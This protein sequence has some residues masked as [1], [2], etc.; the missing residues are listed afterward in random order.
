ME[1]AVEYRIQE[2]ELRNQ[3]TDSLLGNTKPETQN[4]QPINGF[5]VA[6]YDKAQELVIDPFLASTYL[7]G[8]GIDSGHS[9]AIDDDRNVYVTG[10][11]E[12]FDFPTTEGAFDTSFNSGVYGADAFISK[13][14]RN[15]SAP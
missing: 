2:P 1:V 4:P 9:I 13:L 6:S 5:M 11:T 15:L 3:N 8:S 10:Y 14:D 12:S 7:G